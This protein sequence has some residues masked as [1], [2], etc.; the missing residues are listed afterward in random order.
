MALKGVIFCYPMKIV[1]TWMKMRC[2]RC[3]IFHSVPS[4]SRLI[5]LPRKFQSS[6]SLSLVIYSVSTSPVPPNFL[7]VW[8]CISFYMCFHYTVSLFWN[9]KPMKQSLQ[10]R[11]R[12]HPFLSALNSYTLELSPWILNLTELWLFY[13]LLDVCTDLLE[14]KEWR[15]AR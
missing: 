6:S 4:R 11:K 13:S 12:F 10:T 5:L 15:S 3:V 8:N 1:L 14:F 7:K 2:D 9:C